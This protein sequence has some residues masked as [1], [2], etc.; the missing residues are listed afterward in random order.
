MFYLSTEREVGRDPTS[1]VG[2]GNPAGHRQ[3]TGTTG[4]AVEL[5]RLARER[6]LGNV[7]VVRENPKV[8]HAEVPRAR[9]AE[10]LKAATYLDDR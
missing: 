2:P 10:L 7:A 1:P 4:P 5:G 6:E 3:P 8:A 9:L